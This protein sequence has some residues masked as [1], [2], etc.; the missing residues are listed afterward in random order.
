MLN[1][2]G[3]QQSFGFISLDLGQRI[4]ASHPLR[5]V[6]EH[7]DF[8]FVREE[9]RKHYSRF[10][11]C[12]TDPVVV[13]KL[14]FLLYWGNHS[15]TRDLFRQLSYRLDYL[16]FLG[17]SLDSAL[18]DHS[19]LSKCKSRW[20][21]DVFESLFTQVLLK[22]AEAG[23]VDGETFFLDS[24]LIDANADN[25]STVSVDSEELLAQL[26]E[27]TRHQSKKLNGDESKDEPSDNK[28]AA[29]TAQ[30][31]QEQ[32]ECSQDVSDELSELDNEPEQA[33]KEL[34]EQSL[35]RG[36][37]L[38][39]SNLTDPESTLMG[40]RA[41]KYR[42]SRHRYKNHRLIDDDYGVIIAQQ[43]TNASVGDQQMLPS[44]I[45]QSQQQLGFMPFALAADSQYGTH[46]NYLFCE[47]ENILPYFK[48]SLTPKS[49]D[50]DRFTL[51]DFTYEPETNS[52]RCPQGKTLKPYKTDFKRQRQ[53]YSAQTSDCSKCP[54]A[55]KC[56]SP[57]ATRKQLSE[58]SMLTET[59]TKAQRIA[60]SPAARKSRAKRMQMQEGQFGQAARAHHYKRSR[61][62]GLLSQQIQDAIIAAI[63]NVKIL[64][65][66]PRPKTKAPKTSQSSNLPKT[67]EIGNIWGSI[68]L[69]RTFLTKV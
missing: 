19:I 43:S 64:I 67:N 50:S 26:R 36:K 16:F 41:G 14:F 55:Q 33:G 11:R 62:R 69:L 20:G 37:N 29:E 42:H 38:Q 13:M 54:L 48:P 66:G 39:R 6:L 7:V 53:L 49:K 15:S 2:Q 3:N 22:C 27:V 17:L 30:A 25:D 57:K 61:Y 10:G 5:K 1:E 60:S 32:P 58:P 56:L 52:Y 46:H 34:S 24:S 4:P 8:S 47:A 59:L 23:L 28:P 63:Q 65:K 51:E 31:P 21:A 9:V 68:R 18:A 35:N 44:L 12:G 45:Q 40:R